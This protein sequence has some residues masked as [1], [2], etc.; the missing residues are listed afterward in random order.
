MYTQSPSEVYSEDNG[1]SIFIGNA[2]H[3]TNL[4]SLKDKRVS[5]ILNMAARD[6]VC[7]MTPEVY[8]D[9]YKCLR[10]EAG[11]MPG[12]DISQHFEVT[13]E[14]IEEARTNGAKI[15]VHCAAGASRSATVVIAYLM[16][17]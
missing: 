15:L 9:A 14:F 13:R 1:F 4:P 6:P 8:G 17:L 11:D 12:Y 3:A 7:Q 2:T 10:I 5:Y 16:Q